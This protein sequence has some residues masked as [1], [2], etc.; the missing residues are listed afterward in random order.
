MSKNFSLSEFVSSD[1]ARRRGIENVPN[2]EEVS[3]LDELCNSFLQPLRDAWGSGISVTSGYRCAAL[4]KAVG[5]SDTSVH[6]RGWAADLQP[7]NG[8]FDD[9]V[10]FTLAWVA[11]YG[12]KF[13]QILIESKGRTRWLH[14]GLR[15][16]A[17]LQR[18]QI[19]NID[20]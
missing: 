13:D 5:G 2:F 10:H 15:S 9:F 11:K 8:R 6:M 19:K 1:T 14:V 16:N 3:H 18:M 12:Y 4:N 17:G 7:V 20:L